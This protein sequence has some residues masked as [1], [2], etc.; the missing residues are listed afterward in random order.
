MRIRKEISKTVRVEENGR[1][2][3]N[4]VTVYATT[5]ED[6]LTIDTSDLLIGSM[7]IVIRTSEIYMLDADGGEWRSVQ[8]GKPLASGE[9]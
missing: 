2:T 7:L 3:M 4:E 8:D 6:A 9:V 5:A 1:R